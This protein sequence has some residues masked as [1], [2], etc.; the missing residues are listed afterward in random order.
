LVEEDPDDDNDIKGLTEGNKTSRIIGDYIQH[1]S[2]NEELAEDEG[3]REQYKN[4]SRIHR[5][6]A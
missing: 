2:F 5:V 6:F 4:L 3:A 1:E